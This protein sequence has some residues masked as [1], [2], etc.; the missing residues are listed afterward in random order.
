MKSIP[1]ALFFYVIEF[2]YTDFVRSIPSDAHSE[3]YV[4]LSKVADDLQ[5]PRLRSIANKHIVG[6]STLLNHL[7]SCLDSGEYS[8]VICHECRDF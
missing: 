2:L 6:Q 3:V 4:T 1:Y 5:L 7:K 8:D